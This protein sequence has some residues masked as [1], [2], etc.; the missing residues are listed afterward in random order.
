MD[1]QPPLAASSE[2]M[3]PSGHYATPVTDHGQDEA[4][5]LPAMATALVNGVSPPQPLPERPDEAAPTTSAAACGAVMTDRTPT[6]VPKMES[7]RVPTTAFEAA[8]RPSQDLPAQQIP[9]GAFE[10]RVREQTGARIP[11]GAVSDHRRSPM[12]AVTQQLEVVM[13]S[14]V[15]WFREAWRTRPAPY[16]EPPPPPTAALPMPASRTQPALVEHRNGSPETPF[17]VHPI[18]PSWNGLEQP[19]QEPPLFSRQQLEAMAR[20][21]EGHPLIYGPATKAPPSSSAPSDFQ[22]EVRRQ[23]E[24][25]LKD[26]QTV[27]KEL[28]EDNRRLR[29]HI[30][31]TAAPGGQVPAESDHVLPLPPREVPL[32]PLPQR[33]PGDLPLGSGVQAPPVPPRLPEQPS[34]GHPPEAQGRSWFGGLLGGGRVT[35]PPPERRTEDAAPAAATSAHR[36]LGP[37][38]QLPREMAILVEGMSQLQNAMVKQMSNDASPKGPETVKP[39]AQ[40]PQLPPLGED[41]P[42]DYQDWLTQVEAI[43]ADMSD[44]SRT[45]FT[46]VMKEVEAAYAAYLKAPPMDRL[47]LRPTE[48]ENLVSGAYQR[49]HA[50]AATMLMA[51]LP[52]EVKSELVATRRTSVISMLFRLAVLYQPAGEQERTLILRKLQTPGVATTAVEAITIL[53]SWDRWFLR[54]RAIGVVPPDPY[55]KGLSGVCERL[56]P[57]MREASFRTSMLRSRLMLDQNPTEENAKVLRQHLLSE[58]EQVVA[59]S[60]VAK[61]KAGPTPTSASTAAP[62]VKGMNA[63]GS[64][65]TSSD[66][67]NSKGSRAARRAQQPCKFWFKTDQGCTRGARCGFSHSMEGI[68]EKEKIGRCLACSG[69]GHSA[70]SCPTKNVDPGKGKGKGDGKNGTKGKDPANP[71]VAT[72]TTA[73][74]APSTSSTTSGLQPPAVPPEIKSLLAETKE[75]L[76]VLASSPSLRPLRLLAAEMRKAQALLLDSGATHLLRQARDKDEINQANPVMVT[77][78]GD[79]GKLLH[80]ATSGTILTEPDAEP[81]QPII[82]LGQLTEVLGCRVHWTKGACK[83][84]HPTMGVLKVRLRNGCPEVVCQAQAMELV[85][86]LEKRMLD[87]NTRDL[88]TKLLSLAIEEDKCWTDYLHEYLNSGSSG[89]GWKAVFTCPVLAPFEDEDKVGLIPDWTSKDYDAWEAMK[90]VLPLPRRVR[91]RLYASDSWIVA[92]TRDKNR[93]DPIVKGNYGDAT[94]LRVDQDMEGDPEVLRLVT[95]A[96]ADGRV[97]SVVGTDDPVQP[98]SLALQT[99][100]YVMAKT[101][102]CGALHGGFLTTAVNNDDLALNLAMSL[103]VVMGMHEVPLGYTNDGREWVGFTDMSEMR[104]LQGRVVSEHAASHLP[105]EL[106]QLRLRG[107][108]AGVLEARLFWPRISKLTATD[109]LMWANHLKNGHVPYRRDCATC[110]QAAGTGRA[111]KRVD[112]PQPFSLALDVAGPLK[113]KGRSMG[114]IDENKL[115]YMLVG[116]YRVPKDLLMEGGVPEEEPGLDKLKEND[117]LEECEDYAPSEA[118]DL[119]IPEEEFEPDLPPPVP[120]PEPG[121]EST[122]PEDPLRKRIEEL[123]TKVELATLYLMVPMRSRHTHDVLEAAQAMYNKLKRASLP[124]MQIHSDRAREFRARSFRR[125]TIDKGLFHSRTS[126]SE[127]AAN[128]TAECAVKF[129]KRRAR[130]LLITSSAEARDWPLAAQHAAELHWRAMMPPDGRPRDPLPAFGQE[131]WYKI[132]S[133]AGSKEKKIVGPLPDLPPRWRKASYRGVAPDVPGGHVLCRQDGGLVIAK[134]I[135]MDVVEPE[136]LDL[137]PPVAAVVPAEEEI[138][139]ERRLRTK[140]KGVEEITDQ[141]L[142]DIFDIDKRELIEAPPAL[143]KAVTE[144]EKLHP[145]ETYSLEILTKSVNGE[146]VKPNQ[147]HHLLNLL[148]EEPFPRH[149]GGQDKGAK[150]AWSTGVFIHG[151]VAGLKRSTKSFPSTTKVI[152]AYIKQLDP[153]HQW[154]SVAILK[155]YH[156]AMHKDPHNSLH[157]QTLLAPI[158]KFRRGG[159]WVPGVL[160]DYPVVTKEVQGRKVEGHVL[161]VSRGPVKFYPREWHEVAKWSGTRVVLAAYTVRSDEKIKSEDRELA[162]ELGFQLPPCPEAQPPPPSLKPIRVVRDMMLKSVHISATRLA[163]L[164]LD[165]EEIEDIRNDMVATDHTR[166]FANKLWIDRYNIRSAVQIGCE[167]GLE[168]PYRDPNT[169]EN[170]NREYCTVVDCGHSRNR[171]YWYFTYKSDDFPG[172]RNIVIYGAEVERQYVIS[173]EE[174]L[175]ANWDYTRGNTHMGRQT[176]VVNRGEPTAPDPMPDLRGRPLRNEPKRGARPEP[177]TEEP[178]STADAE[179][180]TRSTRRRIM[181]VKISPVQEEIPSTTVQEVIPS[182]TVQE[183]IPSTFVQEVIPSTFVQE[184]IP[185]TTVQEE[186]YINFE[187]SHA[188]P[189]GPLS[190]ESSHAHPGGPLFEEMSEEVLQQMVHSVITE[191]VFESSE[192]MRAQIRRTEVTYTRDIEDLL[193]QL[194]SEGRDLEV[195]HNVDVTEVKKHVDRWRPSAEKEYYN[196][197]DTKEA[198][199]VRT[200]DQLP[201]GTLIVPGKAVVTVKPPPSGSPTHYKRKVRFVVCGNFLEAEEGDLYAAGADASTLRLLLS[202]Y[203]GKPGISLGTTDITQAFVLTPWSGAHSKAVQPP[204]LAVLLGLAQQ[205]EYWLISKALYGLKESPAMWASFRDKEL[206]RA[207]W[208]AEGKTYRLYQ[209]EGD[210]QL[211]K[212]CADG[213]QGQP[214]PTEAHILVYVDDLLMV[215]QT[216][217]TKGFAKWVSEKWECQTPD[218]LGEGYDTVRFLGME[219]SKGSKNELMISQ[220]AFI[221]ELIRGHD[222]QGA[223]TPAMASREALLLTETEEMELLESPEA[224]SDD[225]TAV[226]EAQRRVGELLWLAGRTRPD[227]SYPV[228]LLSAKLLRNP[229]AVCA[230]AHRILGYLKKTRDEALVFG[231][232]DNHHLTNELVVYTDSSFAPSGGRSHGAAVVCYRGTPA[233]WRSSRQQLTTLSTTESELIEALEGCL[234]ATSVVD[235]VADIWGE[236]PKLVVKV[237]NNSAVQLMT[238]S[239]GS[240][241]TRHLRVRSAWLR[242]RIRCGNV[243][244]QH[245]PGVTQLADLGT[246]PMPRQRLEDLRRLWQLRPLPDPT[247]GAQEERR[248]KTVV[249]NDSIKSVMKYLSALSVFCC[250]KGDTNEVTIKE[251]IQVDSSAGIYMIILVI[252]VIAVTMWEIAKVRAH[253]AGATGFDAGLQA[254]LFRLPVTSPQRHRLIDELSGQG[255]YKRS[256]LEY[257]D[258]RDRTGDWL[259]DTLDDFEAVARKMFEDEQAAAKRENLRR[260]QPVEALRRE[261][262]MKEQLLVNSEAQ[263]ELQINSDLEAKDMQNVDEKPG[264]D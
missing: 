122:E 227:L 157:H 18:P 158:T 128:G 77:L 26:Q 168:E 91:K 79:E 177:A 97:V 199:T 209:C 126:G 1:P 108:I 63:E 207:V 259:Q 133:Y 211:W 34:E 237:D 197:R 172:E 42:I 238:G 111:H 154:T 134:G 136:K 114:L 153:G 12:E 78:A 242:E 171:S 226:R 119:F 96:I 135:R 21:R 165:W 257:G 144:P 142:E 243:I 195:T 258:F 205:G 88:E 139:P 25:Y 49:V 239:T 59:A 70:S 123:T 2:V 191:E 152:N 10:Y 212:V 95:W 121:E 17:P 210:P 167:A 228:A 187:S 67:G 30:E 66:K 52:T 234:L 169:G 200:K 93:K 204:R 109:R 130:Q 252:G 198:F 57:T 4:D 76:S 58:M 41:S 54:S 24:D 40:L 170:I 250:A 173:D 69:K 201:P 147:I 11:S 174:M 194:D 175:Q 146:L 251:P 215:G 7:S 39:G 235:I 110:L 112:R 99:W 87:K 249:A 262:D 192:D 84:V 254:L 151:G 186:S 188:H 118:E 160:D 23:V 230:T 213:P 117:P 184:E 50:R 48:P 241:R 180:T 64:T 65:P 37:A 106:H 206:K 28:I 82:P 85:M 90:R 214:G 196:L 72:A 137:L 116:A 143:S 131:V 113:T 46:M 162:I 86:E 224:V 89:D 61:A 248:V 102:G 240:W 36:W 5:L 53:R 223:P 115:K 74:T 6:P 20:A 208:E 105:P 43:M 38:P 203:G 161:Q 129:F 263:R 19:R 103:Q 264:R 244:V 150:K 44:S 176:E 231:D 148:P 261:V 31:M 222:Y 9:P 185:S 75:M 3:S 60:P 71:K 51:S 120:I 221:D 216:C 260:N 16:T 83:V 218:W 55:M 229:S 159:L 182:T 164:R 35:P 155:N 183:V 178:D 92:F 15:Q 256:Q 107:T 202:H 219:I 189:G 101:Y 94:V 47:T 217:A 193:H 8:L 163:E 220:R 127:P 80:Q 232:N 255:I 236:E 225:A 247:S 253:F 81:P 33:Q 141:D 125:W 27:M 132:K 145:A 22:A 14:G 45:W 190:E 245:E 166:D 100:V 104:T 32:P 181:M 179:P 233:I 29:A 62:E 56:L 246:K 140:A 156:T 13:Q 68:T 149:E 73:S 98:R 138:P 124:V